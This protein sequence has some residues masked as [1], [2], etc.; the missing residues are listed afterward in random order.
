LL[1]FPIFGC[2]DKKGR[3][4]VDFNVTS[5]LPHLENGKPPV[6][7]KIVDSLCFVDSVC[8][9]IQVILIFVLKFPNFR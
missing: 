1:K 8:Y 3:S 6:W 5:K 4:G 9:V 7:C 2:H